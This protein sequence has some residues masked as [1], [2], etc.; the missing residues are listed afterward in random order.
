MSRNPDQ[1]YE[2]ELHTK[3]V[4]VEG[5]I[6]VGKSSLAKRLAKDLEAPTLLEKA[7][8][9]PFLEQ[10]YRSSVSYALHV[11]LFF[12]MQRKRQIEDF[13]VKT[14]VGGGLVSDFMIEKDPLFAKVTLDQSEYELY[15]EVYRNLRFPELEFDLVIYLQAPV[16]V[17]QQ[18]IDKRNVSYELGMDAQY[19]E[20]LSDAYVTFFLSYNATP[21]LI[22]NAA[23]I[24]P[25]DNDLHYQELLAHIRQ[26]SVGRHFFNPLA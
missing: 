22:V 2:N 20:K 6:G 24:N 21:L 16:D 5:P 10:F 3:R 1:Q 23:E 11:Q 4:V 18:R 9:N 14:K 26:I 25:V 7:E 17:L 15:Q 8:E 13:I 19:L 12:L